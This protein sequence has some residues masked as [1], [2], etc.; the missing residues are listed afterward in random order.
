METNNIEVAI[1]AYN[2]EID[3]G[4]KK[5]SKNVKE[6]GNEIGTTSKKIDMLTRTISTAFSINEFA[7]WLG[8]IKQVTNQMIILT[9]A[10]VDYNKNMQKLQIAYGEVNSNGE[11]LIRTMA[12]LSGLDEAQLTKSL[13]TFRQYASTLGIVNDKANTLSENLLK[14]TNDLSSFYGYDVDEM[15]SKLISALTGET[16]ALKKLGIDVSDTAIKQKA[17]SLG[18]EE[19]TSNMS[20]ASKTMLRY[21]LIIDQV[22]NA[23]GNFAATINDV[24]NQTKIWNA[25]IDTLKRQLGA[26]LLPI[27][28]GILPVLNGI[29]MVVNELLGML[30]GLIG[31]KIPTKILV[32]DTNK[33]TNGLNDMSNAANKAKKSLRG[34]DKLNVITTPTSGASGVGGIGGVDQKILDAM[35]EYNDML[36]EAHNKATKIRDDIMEWLGFTKDTNGKWEHTKWTIGDVVAGFALLLGAIKGI[37]TVWNLIDFGK[38]L[39]NLGSDA[40]SATGK[41]GGLTSALDKIPTFIKIGIIIVGIAYTIN[42]IKKIKKE[43]EEL[44]EELGGLR[45]KIKTNY[46]DRWS[47]ETDINTIIKEQN[48]LRDVGM[49]N[50]NSA[51]DIGNKILGVS[52]SYYKNAKLTVEQ[53]DILLDALMSQYDTTKLTQD[54]QSKILDTLIEQYNQN[55]GIILALEQAG[56]DTTD[57]KK[58][59]EKYG[60]QIGLVANGLGLS[61]E[62]LNG[63]IEKSS[64]EKTLTKDIYDNI[65]DINKVPLNDKS[66]VYTIT[67][68]A[69]TAQATREYN[70]F[71]QKLG[72][73]IGA[74][75]NPF[76]GSTLTQLK[77]IWY[78]STTGGSGGGGRGFADGGF[79]KQGELFIAREAGAEMVGSIN[80]RTAVA[81]N[82]QIVDGISA[83]VAKAIMATG[84]NVNVNITAEGDTQGLLD[85]IE[86]KQKQKDRQYGF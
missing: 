47:Q 30:L 51:N 35:Q 34:F 77:K 2:D 56:Y 38:K 15:S 36:Q 27:L 54:E 7:P 17:L 10:Q 13:G 62:Q 43:G 9:K 26:L 86:F 70:G 11:K 46:K 6:L 71:F 63:M 37:K 23:Q 59:T 52:D 44:E 58:I 79:P 42:T 81:N 84:R 29:L 16:E 1:K 65:D 82:D 57:L 60:E 12:D 4:L 19:N 61:Q 18:V 74:I 85:F 21:L 75:F 5:T 73:S 8:I 25:Q 40:E 53:S 24:S 14:L 20:A 78:G 45:E 28:Q 69:D 41:V 31:I 48:R 39:F 49:E 72:A 64:T 50:L 68:K 22:K 32:D 83:G 76:G 33:I 55:L 3:K 80:N 66:A 67:A